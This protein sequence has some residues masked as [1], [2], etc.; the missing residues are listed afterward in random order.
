MSEIN[1][2]HA[3]EGGGDP[4]LGRLVIDDLKRTRNFRDI[5]R[6]IKGLY[7]FYLNEENRRQLA[8]MG[9]FKRGFWVIGWLFRSLLMKLNPARRMMLL[10]ALL[11]AV[12]GY[13]SVG[14]ITAD[15]RPWSVALV[16]LILMLEL[17]DKLL[18][19]D[20]I[21][22]A[23]QVQ[24]ALLPQKQPLLGGWAVWSYTRPANHVGGDLVDYVTTGHERLGIVLA[25]VS[26]KGLGAAMLAAKLQ[27]TLRALIPEYQQLDQLGALTNDI[28]HRDGLDNRF[29]T[30]FYAELGHQSGRVRYLNAGHNPACVIRPGSIDCIHASALP[31]GMMEGTVYTEGSIE[32][33][34]GESMLI[35][36][37]GLT[38]ATNEQDEEFGMDRLQ[39]L[40]PELID[41]SPHQAGTRL[42]LVVEEF[43][44]GMQPNDDLSL[45]FLQ[46]MP[47]RLQAN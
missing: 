21:E 10:V 47:E 1:R 30:L 37:D 16:L 8:E 17:K 9:R 13:T 46:R 19:R 12:M 35:Y 34:C 38:E 33:A 29:A 25:D 4:S 36:S 7:S 3:G 31:L 15:L 39:A 14:T 41:L 40:L 5:W 42:L 24:L 45:V 23:R 28:L 43:L 32:I 6:E 2:L 26:G 11:M 18:A 20:E 22:V 44:D 27:S